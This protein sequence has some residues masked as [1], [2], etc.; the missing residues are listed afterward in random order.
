L[1]DPAVTR[2]LEELSAD[3]RDAS[4]A[5]LKRALGKTWD[6]QRIVGEIGTAAAWAKQNR[7]PVIINEFGVLGW[8]A[9]IG[10]RVRWLQTVRAAAEHFCIGWTHWDY[11]DGFGFVRRVGGKETPDE[12]IVGAL[13]NDGL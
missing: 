12:G 4:A 7:R 8:K 11:A 10:D 2:L 6:S 9:A 13:L 3:R 1:S 5:L